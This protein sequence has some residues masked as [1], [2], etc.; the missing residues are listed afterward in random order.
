[1]EPGC[2]EQE[3]AEPAATGVHCLLPAGLLFTLVGLQAPGL[4]SFG[5]FSGGHSTGLEGAHLGSL[6]RPLVLVL[7]QLV[8]LDRYWAEP[9]KRLRKC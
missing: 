7:G 9:G 1:M 3:R 5:I 4:M 8:P 6:L 2:L